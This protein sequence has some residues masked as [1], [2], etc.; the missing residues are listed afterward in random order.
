LVKPV[1]VKSKNKISSSLRDDKNSPIWE[2]DNIPGK[3]PGKY[4][5]GSLDFMFVV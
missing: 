3:K 5:Q 1:D 2:K 4:F